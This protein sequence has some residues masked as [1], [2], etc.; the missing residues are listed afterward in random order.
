LTAAELR[1]LRDLLGKVLAAREAD[2]ADK[3]HVAAAA[4]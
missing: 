4:S 2:R 3:E 1:Q